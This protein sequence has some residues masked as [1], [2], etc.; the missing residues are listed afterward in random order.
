MIVLEETLL[1]AT[2]SSLIQNNNNLRY[3]KNL[4]EKLMR[5]MKVNA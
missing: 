1:K 2:P 5:R 4:K 3:Q